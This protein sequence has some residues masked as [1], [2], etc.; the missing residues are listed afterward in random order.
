VDQPAFR[1]LAETTPAAIFVQRDARLLYVNAAA[2]AISGYSRAELLSLDVWPLLPPEVRDLAR[3]VYAARLRGEPVSVP[4]RREQR[5]IVKNGETRWLDVSIGRIEWGGA[6][7]LLGTA[8]D[9]SDRRRAETARRREERRYRA[10]VEHASD[11]VLVFDATRLV[12]YVGP[13]LERILGHHPSALEGHDLY[14]LLHPDD[15]ELCRSA[16]DTLLAGTGNTVRIQY[17]VRDAD[18]RWRWMEGIG[19]NLMDEPAIGGIV[20]NARDVTDWRA[21]EDQLSESEARFALAIDGAKDGIWDWDMSSETFFV[22]PRMREMLGIAPEDPI[23]VPDLFGTRI[24]PDDQTRVLE[25]WLAHL[26][27][28]S[29][30]YEGEYRYRGADGTYRWFL[31]RARTVRDASGVPLRLVGSL[32]DTTARKAAEEEARQRQAEL[33]HVLRVGAMSEMAASMAHELNQPLAAI[34]N[35]ARG[36]TRRLAQGETAADVLEALDHIATEALRAGEVVHSLK[37]VVRKE[38]PRESP[39]DLPMLVRETVQLVRSDASDRGIG[40]RLE[41]ANDIT[42][43]TGDRVQLQQVVL[44]LLRNAVEAIVQRPGL[45]EVRISAFADGVRLAVS[46]SGSGIPPELLDQIFSPFFTTKDSGLGMGLS[47]SRTI[48]EVHGGRL[49]AEANPGAGATFAFT[50]PYRNHGSPGSQSG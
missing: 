44:N 50:L 45:I 13:S 41:V 40:I 43:V 27:D 23:S 2:E 8:F 38:P 37:R 25:G 34:V 3:A 20:V 14:E 49:W 21:A 15:L 17:R 29:T 47:I 9:V 28:G 19:T 1:V 33:A 36:C 6:P 4:P 35:Y 46:D 10:L 42:S 7:A 22:S 31:V 26:G 30:H 24:H 16:V 12:T 18:G 11:A 5:L 48:I 32:T 39:I